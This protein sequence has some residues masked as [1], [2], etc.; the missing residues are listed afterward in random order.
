MH[1][2]KPTDS[3][4]RPCSQTRTV[5]L[6]PSAVAPLFGGERGLKQVEPGDTIADHL[7]APL[8]G[9]ERGLK[10]PLIAVCTAVA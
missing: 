10:P 1:G 2:R 3:R 5:V 8:F 9:G 7:V 4:Q 6:G